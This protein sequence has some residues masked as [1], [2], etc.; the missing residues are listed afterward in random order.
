MPSGDAR[1]RQSRSAH[2]NPIDRFFR[3]YRRFGRSNALV[4]RP[5]DLPHVTI[6]PQDHGPLSVAVQLGVG[7]GEPRQP[8]RAFNA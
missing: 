8:R 4:E 1:A 3:P 2:F 6:V 5:L 7:R